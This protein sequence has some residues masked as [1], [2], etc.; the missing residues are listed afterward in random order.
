MD[1]QSSDAMVLSPRPIKSE[2]CALATKDRLTKKESLFI[3]YYLQGNSPHKAAI[4]AGYSPFTAE[5]A[6]S[7]ILNRPRV[8]AEIRRLS[9]EIFNEKKIDSDWIISKVTELA[10]ANMLDYLEVQDNGDV[11]VDLRR[12]TRSMGAAIQEF[13]FDPSGRPKIRLVDKK[14]AFDLLARIKKMFNSSDE[15]GEK[16]APLSIQAIDRIVQNVTINQQV[17]IQSQE[18]QEFPELG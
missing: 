12:I 3:Q 15:S 7:L 2:S 11:K 1:T 16:D 17:N 18:R 5:V 10:E 13:S 8:I 14:A 9:D 6:S 4:L